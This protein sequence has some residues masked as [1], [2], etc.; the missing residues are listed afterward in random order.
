MGS[1]EDTRGLREAVHVQLTAMRYPNITSLFKYRTINRNTLDALG[2]QKIWVAS[3]NSFNDPLDTN[4]DN[5]LENL[6]PEAIE[7][8]SRHGVLQIKNRAPND[9]AR[10]STFHDTFVKQAMTFGIL[11]LTENCESTL[12]W[13]H[14][15]NGH[16]GF[17]MEFERTSNGLLGNHDVTAPVSYEPLCPVLD[18][19]NLW[20]TSNVGAFKF[21]LWKM[22]FVKAEEWSYEK[23]W[24]SVFRP[25]NC[26]ED[27]PGPL[28][29]IIWGLRMDEKGKMEIRHLLNGSNVIFKTGKEGARKI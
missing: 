29:S 17:C 5:Y 9:P 8:I 22:M 18:L 23:E 27:Y 15:A 19:S 14:Y 11:S 4:T 28:K 16:R 10:L 1:R 3:P 24:R 12:L 20:D 25:G 7:R 21:E 6:S 26:L 2:N 13:S